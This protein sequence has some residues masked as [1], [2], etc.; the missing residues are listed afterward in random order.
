MTCITE[1]HN[2]DTSMPGIESNLVIYPTVTTA[3][4]NRTPLHTST[5]KV[6]SALR[7]IGLA[8]LSLQIPEVIGLSFVESAC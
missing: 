2:E 5:L 1:S 8:I 6:L 4:T 3:T 7:Y